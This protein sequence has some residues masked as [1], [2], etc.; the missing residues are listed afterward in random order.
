MTTKY[1]LSCSD[2]KRQTID[3]ESFLKDIGKIKLYDI[4]KKN[5][6]GFPLT[7]TDNINPNDYGTF[8]YKGKKKILRYIYDNIIFMDLYN[9]NKSKYYPNISQPE[10][11]VKFK[12]GFGK[13]IIN[14]HKN[15]TL[16][17]EREKIVNRNKNKLMYRN[18]IVMFFDT[19][20]RAHFS[21][22]FPKTINFLKPFFKYET[23]KKK[24]NMTIFE[25]FKYHS[26]NTFTD[27]N[28]IAAYYGG[29]THGNGT[30]FAKYFKENGFI[31]GRLN[32]LCEKEDV[33]NSQ[34]RISFIHTRFDH[35]G[36]SLQCIKSF[37]KGMLASM[38]SS[39]VEKCLFGKDLYILFKE[40]NKIQMV[41]KIKE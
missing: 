28:I 4:S 40:I 23:D 7:N 19:L 27:P 30:H 26:L 14:V 37:F 12:D 16:I 18:V 41:C 20:S 36:I 2:P 6:F 17:N 21:R 10:I 35:E 32:G 1:N 22:K 24:K 11:E 39:L 3:R 9:K 31:I 8:C 38:G 15:I 13:L 25:Y 34:N 33:F 5:H 29:K